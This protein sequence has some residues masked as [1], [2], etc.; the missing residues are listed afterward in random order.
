MYESYLRWSLRPGQKKTHA[1]NQQ[2]MTAGALA[3]T[4][5]LFV[6]PLDV[7]KTQIQSGLCQSFRESMRLIW[8]KGLMFQGATV[9]LMRSI[10]LNAVSFL[11]FEKLQESMNRF[12]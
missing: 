8:R 5:H 11:I 7:I 3:G 2:I 10:P 9:T 1:S 4:Y 12:F 6:Y